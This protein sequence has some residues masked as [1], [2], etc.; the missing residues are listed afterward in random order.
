MSARSLKLW[1]FPRSSPTV[2]DVVMLAVKIEI[3]IIER[4]IHKIAMVRPQNV[5]GAASPYPSVVMVTAA[6][7][8]SGRIIFQFFPPIEGNRVTAT[9]KMPEGI[10]VED[11]AVAAAQIEEASRHLVAELEAR[12]KRDSER[13]AAPLKAADDAILLDTTEMRIDEVV[14]QVLQ[15][16][17][18]RFGI[19]AV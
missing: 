9:L 8:A 4:N 13:A 1:T 16:A 14:N 2:S 18:Q 17:S 6:M 19:N 10:N 3:K 11:T 12:D 15:M 7:F 5:L